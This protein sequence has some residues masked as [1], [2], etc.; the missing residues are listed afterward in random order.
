MPLFL[1][2]H[3]DGSV[4]IMNCLDREVNPQVEIEKWPP[5]QKATVVGIYEMDA[6]PQ[7]RTF[8]DAWKAREGKIEIDME[9]A[10]KIWG[11]KIREARKPLLTELDA[12]FFKALEADDKVR[13]GEIAAKKQ[14]LRDMPQA[15]QIV[16]ATTPEELKAFWPAE[17]G[18]TPHPMPPVVDKDKPKEETPT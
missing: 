11:D 9:K 4:S 6:P 17:L 13:Q 14:S 18:E 2:E 8:R 16:S 7:D 12:D 1:I 5:E 15:P 3:A 10:K